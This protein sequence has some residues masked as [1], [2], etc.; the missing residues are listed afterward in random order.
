LEIDAG[1]LRADDAIPFKALVGR[2]LAK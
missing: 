1:Y 2:H